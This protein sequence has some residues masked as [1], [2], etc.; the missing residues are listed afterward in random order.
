M[1]RK[2]SLTVAAA[3]LSILCS[4]AHATPLL[5]NGS[6]E[7]P[8]NTSTQL[9]TPGSTA[10]PGWTVTGASNSN[11]S[12][13]YQG[14][15]SPLMPEDGNYYLD[16]TG[17]VDEGPYVG[18]TQSFSTTSG[19]TYQI[20]FYLGS[21][22]QYQVQDGLT[23]SADGM[24]ETFTS[25]NDGTNTNLWQFESFSFVANGSTA[26]LLFSGESGFAYI[27]LDNVVATDVGVVG[28]TPVPAALPLFATGLGALGMFGWRR[29]RKA[30][31]VAA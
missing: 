19:D 2:S 23:V 12:W 26:N 5:T 18:V 20:T 15:Y 8:G 17:S 24:S 27:G 3:T 21:A 14:A 1:I 9:L 25:T 31:A 22:F 10:I 28:T 30:Q 6:F 7:D 11:I 13:D 16:L 29:K 4:G